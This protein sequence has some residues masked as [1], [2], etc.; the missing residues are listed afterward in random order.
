MDS[1]HNPIAENFILAVRA[2]MLEIG[3]ECIWNADQ[4]AVNYET[5]SNIT[6]D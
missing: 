3:V 4:A 1:L 2:K 5:V 6:I